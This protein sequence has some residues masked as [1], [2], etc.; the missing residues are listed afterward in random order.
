MISEAQKNLVKV[1]YSD[2]DLYAIAELTS[3]FHTEGHRADIVILKTSRALAAFENRFSITEEDIKRSAELTLPHRIIS[4]HG[5]DNNISS[6]E[7]GKKAAQILSDMPR[8]SESKNM[9]DALFGYEDTDKK[10]LMN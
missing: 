1:A 5:T 7:I 2:Q 6:L 10:K 4:G 3:A 9:K 8:S